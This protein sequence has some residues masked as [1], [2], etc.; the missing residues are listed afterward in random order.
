ML[1]INKYPKK[2]IDNCR[3]K[4]EKQLSSYENLLNSVRKQSGK[5]EIRDNSAL[6]I[7]ENNFFNNMILVLDILFIHRSRTL[8]LKNGNPA[9]EVRM[10]SNSIMTNGGKLLSDKTIQYRADISILKFKIGDKIRI[11]YKDF[12]V[13]SKAYFDDIESK[14]L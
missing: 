6:E 4:I 13:L 11:K 5:D 9:N 1:S 7:F 12:V 3:K 10:L 8:E 2:Y 14:F